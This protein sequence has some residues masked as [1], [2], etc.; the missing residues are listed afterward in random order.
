MCFAVL[1]QISGLIFEL[2]ASVTL[3]AAIRM[4]LRRRSSPK[5]DTAVSN[6]I[7][8]LKHLHRHI[9]MVSTLSNLDRKRI[10]LND[11]PDPVMMINMI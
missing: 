2:I 11:P 4:I 10:K 9:L 7:T 5:I 1:S 6:N 8:T 3:L